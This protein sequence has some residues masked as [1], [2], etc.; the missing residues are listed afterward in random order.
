[1][2]YWFFA[3]C[4]RQWLSFS[5]LVFVRLTLILHIYRLYMVQ[6]V[7][8][9]PTAK[10]TG[11]RRMS[12]PLKPIKGKC[13]HRWMNG[14]CVCECSVCGMFGRWWY[15]AP[16]LLVSIQQGTTNRDHPIVEKLFSCTNNFWFLLFDFIAYLAV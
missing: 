16:G 2:W 12:P 6:C 9:F 3:M 8:V 7:W 5:V 4:T 13:A 14:K 1:M 15:R 10:T 11:S